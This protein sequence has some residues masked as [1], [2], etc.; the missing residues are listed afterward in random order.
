MRVRIR[1]K[2]LLAFA[3]ILLLSSTVNIYGL[4]QIEVLAGLTTKIY[5]LLPLI[6]LNVTS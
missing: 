4:F 6:I 5:H 2:L 3:I 1:T